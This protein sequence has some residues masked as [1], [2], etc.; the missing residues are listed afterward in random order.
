MRY[1]SYD[2]SSVQVC[3]PLILSAGAWTA[4][5]SLGCS[6]SGTAVFMDPQAKQVV[7]ILTKSCNAC[8]TV[9]D[10]WIIFF[11]AYTAATTPRAF[12]WAEQPKNYPF[13]WGILIPSNTQFLRRTRVIHPNDILIVSAIFAGHIRVTNTQTDRPRYMRHP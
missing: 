9:T 2:I 5:E 7:G 3:Y 13:P 6:N 11:A 1:L 12:S 4:L 10:D 8:R